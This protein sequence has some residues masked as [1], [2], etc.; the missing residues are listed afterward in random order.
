MTP[1]EQP[2]PLAIARAITAVMGLDGSNLWLPRLLLE[3]AAQDHFEGVVDVA[4]F[5]G[6]DACD[7][8]AGALRATNHP[9]YRRA[10]CV[11]SQD[12][13]LMV[14]EEAWLDP[15][16]SEAAAILIESPIL[17]VLLYNRENDR[18]ML[19]IDATAW[20]DVGRE[21]VAPY[22]NSGEFGAPLAAAV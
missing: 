3:R 8:I 14:T 11:V 18:L 21:A 16:A 19:W 4:D 13:I 6:L 1:A 10:G 5:V 22:L 20:A 17:L 7:V 12:P 15:Q 9:L 2:N